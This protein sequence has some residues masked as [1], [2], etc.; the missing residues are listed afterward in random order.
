[1]TI[2]R[3]VLAKDTGDVWRKVE[4]KVILTKR[5]MEFLALYSR[6][7]SQKRIA[8][9]L[10]IDPRTVW[11]FAE[12]LRVKFKCGKNQTLLELATELRI[13]GILK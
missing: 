4:S 2:T 13:Q 11:A 8:Q 12:S 1:M 9:V 7:Y 10:K 3:T 6:G 5:E